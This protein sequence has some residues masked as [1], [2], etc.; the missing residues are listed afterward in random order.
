MTFEEALRLSEELLLDLEDEG[1]TEERNAQLLHLLSTVPACRGFFVSFLTGECG[2]ADDPPDYLLAA[3]MASEHVPE[4]MAK[5]L[6]MSSCME[7]QHKRNGDDLKAEG[8]ARVKA[9]SSELIKR[10]KSAQMR[11]RLSEMRFSIKSKTGIHA[12]FLRRW[13]YD[14]DQLAAACAAIEALL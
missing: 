5:N 3:F 1:Q 8:S 14:A 10:L 13:N 4:L 7:L 2:L 9:R 11:S 12:E 6:V